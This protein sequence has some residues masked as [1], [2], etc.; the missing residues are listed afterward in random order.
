MYGDSSLHNC[1]DTTG[2][3]MIMIIIILILFS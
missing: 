1:I 2:F 3:F